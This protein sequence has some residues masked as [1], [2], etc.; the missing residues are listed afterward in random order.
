MRTR[1][2]RAASLAGG[3]ALTLFISSTGLA[4]AE[5][6]TRQTAAVR[7]HAQ[8]GGT[9]LV[10]GASA[11]LVRTDSGISYRFHA[12]ALTPGH[13]YTLWLVV[14]DQPENCANVPCAAGDFLAKVEPDAQVTYA[15]GN[16]AGGSG[17]ATFSGHRSLGPIDGWLAGRSFDNPRGAEVHLVVN[18]HG[19]KLSDHMPGMIHTYRGGCSDDSPFPAIFPSTAL[20]DG[21]PGPNMCLLTQAA[22]FQP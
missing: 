2:F 18:D 6:A 3:L 12:K 10:E 20:E 14:I 13:A 11:S 15:A 5:P 19:P 22:V 7:W 16:V 8:T 21:E 1:N 9:D 4:A 17:A